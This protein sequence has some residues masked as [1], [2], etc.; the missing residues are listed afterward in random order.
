MEKKLLGLSS[1]ENMY[2]G[3]F[4][5]SLRMS[6]KKSL[7][8][9]VTAKYVLT[10]FLLIENVWKKSLVLRV[11]VKYVLPLVLYRLIMLGKKGCWC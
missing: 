7:R 4:L 2:S 1:L 6:G 8:L 9:G 10:F 5:Y 3:T 11:T